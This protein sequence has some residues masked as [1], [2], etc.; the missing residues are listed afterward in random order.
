M[1]KYFLEKLTRSRVLLLRSRSFIKLIIKVKSRMLNTGGI[2]GIN[3]IMLYFR[4]IKRLLFTIALVDIST[5]YT[6]Y[7]ARLKF[8]NKP[9]E[10]SNIDIT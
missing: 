8:L 10:I 7:K 1:V 4:Y 3:Y 6:K 9:I 2:L 5:L